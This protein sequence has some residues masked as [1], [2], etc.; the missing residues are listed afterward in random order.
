MIINL[1]VEQELNEH[2][3]TF[4]KMVIKVKFKQ[5]IKLKT[6]R[7]ITLMVFFQCVLYTFGKIKY[8]LIHYKL[9]LKSFFIKRNDSIFDIVHFKLYIRINTKP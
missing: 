5:K 7:N 2:N 6:C 3:I 8:I 9:N 4:D 1:K